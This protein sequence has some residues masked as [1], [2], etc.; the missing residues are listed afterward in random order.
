MKNFIEYYHFDRW[1]EAS[2][3]INFD[4]IGLLITENAMSLELILIEIQ[5]HVHRLSM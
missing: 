2:R 3:Q 1:G 4:I 5:V